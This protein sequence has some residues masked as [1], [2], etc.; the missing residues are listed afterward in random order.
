MKVKYFLFKL[1]NLVLTDI[2]TTFDLGFRF[3][4]TNGSNRP[5]HEPTKWFWAKNVYFYIEPCQFPTNFGLNHLYT[6]SVQIPCQPGSNTCVFT[7]TIFLMNKRKDL[8]ISNLYPF[9]IRK[10]RS[11]MERHQASKKGLTYVQVHIF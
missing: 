3:G 11:N 5:K 4:C 1:R 8:F 2:T 7:R 9:K 10:A 6:N